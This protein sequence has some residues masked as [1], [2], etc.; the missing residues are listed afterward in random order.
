MAANH[1]H[2]DVVS[3]AGNTKHY[4]LTHGSLHESNKL[5]HLRALIMRTY[6]FLNNTFLCLMY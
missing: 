6:C 3:V 2:I 1:F 4:P 5:S